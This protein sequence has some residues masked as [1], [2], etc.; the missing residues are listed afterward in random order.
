V[1]I[2]NCW[3]HVSIGHAQPGGRVRARLVLVASERVADL[4]RVALLA[5]RLG[6][7]GGVVGLALDLVAEVLGGRLLRVGLDR[8][9]D[10]VGERLAAGCEA[11]SAS[12]AAGR[13]G[14]YCRTWCGWVRV[15]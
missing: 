10:L 5:L 2:D 3:G 9:A 1:V 6:V 7:A 15:G 11:G 13:E 4:L 14:A 8:S 12:A